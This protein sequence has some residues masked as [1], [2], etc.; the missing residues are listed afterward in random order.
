[1]SLSA[2]NDM[3]RGRQ[4]I[5]VWVAEG[6]SRVFG[7]D[8]SWLLFGEAGEA[9]ADLALLGRVQI[10]AVRGKP[11]EL[12]H[13]VRVYYVEDGGLE[14]VWRRGQR[15]LVVKAERGEK[16]PAII[17]EGRTRWRVIAEVF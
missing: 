13:G 4:G 7:G 16:G 9:R 14:P 8:P 11:L 17:H 12:P 5:P 10:R 2:L 15:L 1:M 6:V 3:L